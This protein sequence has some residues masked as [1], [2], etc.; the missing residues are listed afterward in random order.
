MTDGS[1]IGKLETEMK[2]LATLKRKK[3]LLIYIRKKSQKNIKKS[4]T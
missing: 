4:R 3:V 2:Q 1:H